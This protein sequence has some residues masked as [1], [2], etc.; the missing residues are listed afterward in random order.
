MENPFIDKSDCL[1]ADALAVG[2][3]NF[4]AYTNK[5]FDPSTSK[6]NGNDVDNYVK[7]YASYADCENK[8]D[9]GNTYHYLSNFAYSI[10]S[11]VSTT[12]MQTMQFSYY[13]PIK[14]HG[15][16][17][18]EYLNVDMND[19]KKSINKSSA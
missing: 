4:N 15:F 8:N 16:I 3:K 2:K 17:P 5:G 9:D 11:I 6:V 12:D 14:N 19:V 10:P 1:G 13:N 18:N 7:A